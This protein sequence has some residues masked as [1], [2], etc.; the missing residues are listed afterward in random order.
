MLGLKVTDEFGEPI[1]FGRA[2]GRFFGK[3]FSGLLLGIGFMQIGWSARKQ[4]LHD[5]MASTLV[6]SRTQ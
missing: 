4:G 6:V 3:L 5:L 2:T 1:G